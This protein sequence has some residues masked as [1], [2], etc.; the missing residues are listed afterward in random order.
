MA[1]WT[2]EESTV[3]L[4]QWNLPEIHLPSC[5]G[6]PFIQGVILLQNQGGC[7]AAAGHWVPL[8][9]VHWG[10]RCCR[11]RAWLGVGTGWGTAFPLEL[12][13]PSALK[14]LGPGDM[15]TLQRPAQRAL[16]NPAAK[17]SQCLSSTHYWQNLLPIGQGIIF[18]GPSSIFMH[19]AM[20]EKFRAE[21]QYIDNWHSASFPRVMH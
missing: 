6:N 1:C 19:Q 3:V 8:S 15:A 2:T 10:A 12:E 7:C 20:K 13:G 11:S 9:S 4:H 5:W 21:R 14:Q 17:P 18:I 16:Q